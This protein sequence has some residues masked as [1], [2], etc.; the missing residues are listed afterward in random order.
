MADYLAMGK[1]ELEKEKTALEKSYQ[2][3]RDCLLYTSSH[4]VYNVSGSFQGVRP[5]AAR[6]P[7]AGLWPR[8]KESAAITRGNGCRA[9]RGRRRYWR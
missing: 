8:R 6:R 2:E 3:Y 9:P 7:V 1:A 4:T 5:A